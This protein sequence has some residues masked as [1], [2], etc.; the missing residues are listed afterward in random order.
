ML[1][2]GLIHCGFARL[3]SLSDPALAYGL[4]MI[5]PVG[6]ICFFPNNVSRPP[7]CNQTTVF[8]F[9]G[10]I[11]LN[12]QAF[13][14]RIILLLYSV[15][16]SW[17]IIEWKIITVRKVSLPQ[18]CNDNNSPRFIRPHARTKIYCSIWA[19]G[20]I[21]SCY[22]EVWDYYNFGNGDKWLS[23]FLDYLLMSWLLPSLNFQGC[24]L[25]VYF[26]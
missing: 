14:V 9:H 16:T 24:Q 22:Y 4:A 8:H 7:M 10:N 21:Q 17:C 3:F 2:V 11:Y 15:T 13:L 18:F 6:L 1:H 5:S 19:Y 12:I 25:H 20:I 26:P 23:N